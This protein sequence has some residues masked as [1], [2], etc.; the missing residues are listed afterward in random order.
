MTY[1]SPALGNVVFVN[2]TVFDANAPTA[3]A[4]LDLSPEVGAREVMVYLSMEAG[5]A[6]R[7]YRFKTKGQAKDPTQTIGAG[8]CATISVNA[9]KVGYV[10]VKTNALG[11]IQ[12]IVQ[13]NTYAA[14][15]VLEAYWS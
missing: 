15:I 2:T 13:A 7:G 9:N 11:V 5:A 3:W 10:L 12:W 1:T 14:K 8:G 6:N 4:D